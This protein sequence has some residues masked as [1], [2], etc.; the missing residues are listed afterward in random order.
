MAP[1]S[2]SNSG[3]VPTNRNS[4]ASLRSNDSSSFRRAAMNNAAFNYGNPDE[5]AIMSGGSAR[6]NAST[7]SLRSSS[8]SS[9]SSAQSDASARAAP[10]PRSRSG[11][12]FQ[13]GYGSESAYDTGYDASSTRTARDSNVV[14]HRA[15]TTVGSSGNTYRVAVVE[16]AGSSTSARSSR[17]SG[18]T[19]FASSRAPDSIRSYGSSASSS[20]RRD[21]DND[22][23]LMPPPSRR[24]GPSSRDG[25][26]GSGSRSGSSRH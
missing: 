2:R 12:H 22:R 17:L 7:P 16:P 14:R 9:R 25:G 15:T 19:I 24:S 11:N 5:A 21:G 26:S 3:R 13:A 23:L 10:D 4:S 8:H 18:D 20:S 1:S 6:H